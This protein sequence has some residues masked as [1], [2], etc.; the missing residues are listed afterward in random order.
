MTRIEDLSDN[1]LDTEIRRLREDLH[2]LKTAQRVGAPNVKVY[3]NQTAS[4]SDK[5]VTLA[6]FAFTTFTL[7]FTADTQD[8]AKATLSY[9][10]YV[11]SLSVEVRP[12][13]MS[14]FPPVL[15]ISPRIASESTPRITQ[16]DI[17]VMCAEGTTT[18]YLFKF[19]VQSTDKGVI[20]TT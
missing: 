9:R 2:T 12:D 6:P 17:N 20:T 13:G 8:Y 5:S 4:P 3:Y 1:H 15:R 10:M 7:T 11:G 16:W 19:N 14:P 18:T